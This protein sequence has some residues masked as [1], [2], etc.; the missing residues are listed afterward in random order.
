MT[1]SPVFGAVPQGAALFFYIL[2]T[3]YPYDGCMLTSFGVG[4]ICFAAALL[5]LFGV[6]AADAGWNIFL[7]IFAFAAC[8][9]TA[10]LFFKTERVW[11]RA[12]I[13]L[14]ALLGGIFYFRAYV[15]WQTAHN[16][17]PAGKQETFFGVIQEEPKAAGNFVILPISLVKPYTGTVD[18][19]V[20]RNTGGGYSYGDEVWVQG[21]VAVSKDAGEPPAVFLPRVRVI[22]LHEGSWLKEAMIDLKQ[23]I[24]RVIAGI[25]PADQAALLSG[26]MIGSTGAISAV[27]KNQMDISGTTYIVNM[28]GYKIAILA[29][30]LA[31]ALK[32]HLPRRALSAVV[33]AVI[34]LFVMV[35]GGSASAVRAGVMGSLAVVARGT[36]RVFNARNAVT[37]AALG[38]VLMNATLLTDAGFRLSFLSFLGIYY[39]G[40]PINNLFRWTNGGAFQWKEHSMLSLSTN[41]AILPIVM[42]T[43]GEFSLTSF[44]SNV[45]IMIPWVVILTLGAPVIVL[46][47]VSTALTFG[48]AQVTGVL[49]RY[50]LFI[51]R[52]FSVITV[53]MPPVFGSAFVVA[54]Y[55]GSL[56]LFSYYYAA[57]PEKGY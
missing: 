40:P 24:V 30:A 3:Q 2:L 49:L 25:F 31:F 16:K 11:K 54:L 46:G 43:F 33:L 13:F 4:D 27:L 47:S 45:L 44:L 6:F 21:T 15:L 1:S 39:L 29:S 23:G 17:F 35:S 7:I 52:I 34:A 32:D 26:I 12:V 10:I 50:E 51:I 22:A 57:P 37:F 56:I 14:F 36:G 9:A 5:F 48:V 55:Y 38:M 18:I 20:S 41:L 8:A 53:P 28:Y 42:N 19:F